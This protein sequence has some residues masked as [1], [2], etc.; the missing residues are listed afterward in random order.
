MQTPVSS[1]ATAEKNI[2]SDSPTGKEYQGIHAG[3]VLGTGM[4]HYVQARYP[5]DLRRKHVTGVVRVRVLVG[6][7]GVPRKITVLGGPKQL[8]PYA[9]SAVQLWRYKPVVINGSQVGVLAGIQ[10]PFTLAQ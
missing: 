8:V 3:D 9:I 1:N 5:K 10:V 6:K 2:R 4:V 7:D